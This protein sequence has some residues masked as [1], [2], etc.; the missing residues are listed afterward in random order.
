MIFTIDCFA[1]PWP[2]E[3]IMLVSLGFSLGLIRFPRKTEL[4]PGGPCLA[5]DILGAKLGQKARQAQRMDS[6]SRIV[7]P[8]STVCALLPFSRRLYFVP[9][10]G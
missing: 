5:V 7:F 6:L 10:R 2:W 8:V 9:F 1:G 4:L 3:T